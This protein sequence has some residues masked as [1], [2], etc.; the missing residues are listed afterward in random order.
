M[1][2]VAH[3]QLVAYALL[4]GTAAITSL[5]LTPLVRALALRVRAVDEPGERRVHLRPVPRLGGLAIL[6][7]CLVTLSLAPR[8]GVPAYA[9]LI[10]EGRHLRWLL[11]GIFVTVGTGAFDDVRGLHPLPKLGLQLVA[12]AMAVVGGYGLAGITNPF[13]G[14]WIE[15]GVLGVVATI[16]WIIAIT[17]AL[18]LIDGLDGLA[19]GVAMIASGTLL[20]LAL[21]EGWFGAAYLWTTLLGALAGFLCYNFNPASIFLGDSGS[22]LLGYLLAVFAI[23]SREKGAAAVIAL[24]PVLALGLP[25]MEVVLTLLRRVLLTGVAS[26]FH[27]DR[28]HIHHRLIGRGMSQRGAV[29]TLYGVCVAFSAVAFLAVAVQGAGKAVVVGIAALAMY[30]GIRALGYHALRRNAG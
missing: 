22:L 14:A 16:V 19:V 20:V 17:N 29:L 4:G 26:V 21:A 25:I 9:L 28:E 6:G 7:S 24:V 18:N 5:L 10:G 23:P 1:D 30:G 12:A 8:F 13:T 2:P 11:G 15:F 27:P 3:E